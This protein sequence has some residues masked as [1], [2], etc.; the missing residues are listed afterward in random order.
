MLK[1]YDELVKVN[2]LPYC[3]EREGFMYLN[4]AKCM[5]LLRENGAEKVYFELCQNERTGNSLFVV[6]RRFKTKMET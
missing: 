2:V 1:P 6:I 4:W 5:E 3:A